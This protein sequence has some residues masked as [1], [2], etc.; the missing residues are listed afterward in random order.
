MLEEEKKID[1]YSLFLPKSPNSI[2]TDYPELKEH[3]SLS[4]LNG[5]EFMFVWYYAC[6][7]SP[8][9]KVSDIYKRAEL[10]LDRSFS[11]SK[12]RAKSF[13]ET[14]RKNY[15]SCKFPES[16]Q[17]GILTMSSFRIGPRIKAVQALEI[18]FNNITTMISIEAT[19][20]DFM[21]G[22][23]VDW[24]K[25]KNYIDSV[26]T[27]SE[28]IPQLV[29]KMES[30]LGLVNVESGDDEDEDFGSKLDNYHEKGN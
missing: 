20:E 16:V 9:Y 18:A 23:E 13:S 28:V 15:L 7:C 22:G 5:H 10:A 1:E 19:D 29:D 21:K 14:Q 4:V 25:K 27:A 12:H 8:F 26:K 11:A 2:F 30:K 3:H 6:E 17:N 24:A